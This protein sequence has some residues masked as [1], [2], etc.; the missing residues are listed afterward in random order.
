MVKN[1]NDSENNVRDHPIKVTD[2]SLGAR[3]TKDVISSLEKRRENAINV[4]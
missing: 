4:N 1:V 3:S 2:D